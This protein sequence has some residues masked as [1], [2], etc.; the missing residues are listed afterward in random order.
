MGKCFQIGFTS[1]GKILAYDVMYY[2]NAGCSMDLSFPVSLARLCK[3]TPV[4]V[5]GK[6]GANQSTQ[7]KSPSIQPQNQR[8]ILE[9]KIDRC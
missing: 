5:Q 3:P 2:V 8:H 9:R 1:N 4:K 7:R 6:G